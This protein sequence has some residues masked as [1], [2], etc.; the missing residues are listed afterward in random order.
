MTPLIALLAALNVGPFVD[1]FMA[2]KMAEDHIPGAVFVFV[3]DGKV[4]YAKG[5]GLAD[6]ERKVPV[7]PDKTVWRIGSITKAVTATAV[8]QLVDRGKVELDRDVNDYLRSV[9]VPATYPRP[10]TVRDLLD[11]TAGLDEIRPGTQAP[12]AGELLPLADFLRP[13]LVRVRPSGEIIS[14][15]TY[16]M[17]LAGLLIEDVSGLSYRDYLARHIWAPLR[18]RRASVHVPTDDRDFAVGYELK[19][20]ALVRQPWE[21]YHTAPASSM[22]ATAL[23]MAAF[24]RAH[25]NRGAPLLG[26]AAATEM[27]RQQI[28]M[29]PK[30]PGYALGFYE[31]FV[32]SLRVLEHGGNVAGISTLMV[33]VP[34]HGDGFFI[35]GH[36]ESSKLRDD[37]K[38]ALLEHLYAEARTR[39]PVPAPKGGD[40]RRYAGLYIPTTSC[41]SCKPPSAPSTIRVT[42]NEDGTITFAGGKWTE[43]EPGLFVRAEGT[44]Y[45]VFR[46][47]KY[48]FAGGFWS[49]EKVGD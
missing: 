13:R 14:Y 29:H 4:V 32:G 42:A 6:V 26:P 39:H 38:Y 49:W 9:K 35:A 19:N 34:S 46:G 30:I 20:G 21:W 41:H 10:I 3:H 44:G 48:V 17:T 11:H 40:V 12:S 28:T 15:S 25:L 23:E 36:F 8:M 45:I 7:S 18:M 22:N 24:I 43:V 1:G 33:L 5:Y 16:G 31:D 47:D 27:H 2:K 37:L